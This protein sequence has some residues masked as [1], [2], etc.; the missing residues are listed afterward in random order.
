[1]VDAGNGSST[2]SLGDRVAYIARGG[3]A[4]AEY[5]AIPESQAVA[6][7]LSLS[8][9]EAVSILMDGLVALELCS[10]SFPCNHGDTVV[11][12]RFPWSLGG[13]LIR[14]TQLRGAN[15][16]A[17]ANTDSQV[18]KLKALGA[19]ASV[20]GSRADALDRIMEYTKGEG[21]RAVFDGGSILD[22]NPG[23]AAL[24]EDGRIILH[25]C[26]R[27]ITAVGSPAS[28]SEAAGVEEDFVKGFEKFDLLAKIV[29]GPKFKEQAEAVFFALAGGLLPEPACKILTLS[30]SAE[31]HRWMET[32][33]F[34]G[35]ILLSV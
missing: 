35:K 34:D 11:I 16:I 3:G 4:Y 15:V 26:S 30:Q 20:V 12:Q 32:G 18:G 17:V 22:Q 5:A 14:M 7:P 13:L 23:R 31:A 8:F 6:I 9:R 19:I 24:K 25:D 33:G 29:N 21:V 1:V 27:N 2:F 28:F 10:N